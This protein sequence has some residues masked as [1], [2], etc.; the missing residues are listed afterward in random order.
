[1][2]EKENDLNL[3]MLDIERKIKEM[4][5]SRYV[6]WDSEMERYVISVGLVLLVACS[7]IILYSSFN[8]STILERLISII[9]VLLGYLFGYLPIK[10]NEVSAVRKMEKL[11]EDIKKIKGEKKGL[12]GSSN[13]VKPSL[14]T[15]VELQNENEK[16]RDAYRELESKNEEYENYLRKLVNIE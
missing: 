7:L 10:R 2:V 3:R 5:S 9:T 16:L 15:I 1:M 11:E 13:I 14:V 6:G 12:E 8:D 4:D